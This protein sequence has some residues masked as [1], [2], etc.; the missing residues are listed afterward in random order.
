MN[1]KIH[2]NCDAQRND[3]CS[4]MTVN[5]AALA[6]LQNLL[7]CVC[8]CVCAHATVCMQCSTG[9]DIVFAPDRHSLEL[10]A[11]PCSKIL[12][13]FKHWL[14]ECSFCMHM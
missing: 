4:F 6:G 12:T 8:A 7:Q 13:A 14:G 3:M 9:F 2:S 10:K 1:C 5:N 11:S